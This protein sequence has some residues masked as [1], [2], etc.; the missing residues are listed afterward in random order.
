M[1]DE[2]AEDRQIEDRYLASQRRIEADL[3]AGWQGWDDDQLAYLQA[4]R[5]G[6]LAT[7]RRDGAAELTMVGYGLD[8]G[9]ALV[10]S[11]K[12]YTPKHRTVRRQPKVALIVHDDAKQLVIY[13]TAE[14]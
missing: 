12:R 2:A 7:G 3:S 1:S 4:H 6:V 10:I 8:D 13:G 11:A 14:G 9:G 5:W